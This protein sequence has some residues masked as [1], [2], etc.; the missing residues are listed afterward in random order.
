MITIFMATFCQEGSCCNVLVKESHR[1][2][3]CFLYGLVCGLGDRFR[4]FGG[5][6]SREEAH[7]VA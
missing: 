7:D 3:C 2:P 6:R 4:C 1:L 5:S